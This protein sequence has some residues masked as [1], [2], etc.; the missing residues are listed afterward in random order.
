M[1]SPKEEEKYWPTVK[2]INYGLIAEQFI[3]WRNNCG[4][5]GW[6]EMPKSDFTDFLKHRI[7]LQVQKIRERK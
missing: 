2:E 5:R 3:E 1:L 4:A 6:Y 7:A